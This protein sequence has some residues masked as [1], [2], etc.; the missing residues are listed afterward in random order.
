MKFDKE[1]YERRFRELIKEDIEKKEVWE[2]I[3]ELVDYCCSNLCKSMLRGIKI[4]PEQF[5]IRYG[6][7]VLEIMENIKLRGVRPNSLC[8]YAYWPCRRALINKRVQQ[9]D[10]ETN[11][12]EEYI[13]DEYE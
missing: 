8:S 12:Y 13:T 6:E 10:K 3:W 4:S 1:Y 7:A 2:Q 5:E 9:E 11:S